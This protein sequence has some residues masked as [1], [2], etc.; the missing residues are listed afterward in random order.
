MIAPTRSEAVQHVRAQLD[1]ENQRAEARRS[2]FLLTPSEVLDRFGVPT[3]TES[4]DNTLW[5][6]WEL[7]DGNNLSI[8]FV[9]G[10][11]MLF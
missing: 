6:R 10:V 7:R 11:A 8:G 5:W 2:M 9:N 3:D 1:N 4:N